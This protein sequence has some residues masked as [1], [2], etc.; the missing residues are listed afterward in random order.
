MKIIESF[1][2]DINTSMKEIQENTGKQIE[3]LKEETNKFLK[4]IQEIKQVKEL[5]KT[6]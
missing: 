1:M 2:E 5:D 6:I 4:K 3:P